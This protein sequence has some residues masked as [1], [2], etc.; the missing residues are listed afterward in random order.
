MRVRK[1]LPR[2]TSCTVKLTVNDWWQTD[3]DNYHWMSGNNRNDVDNRGNAD[4]GFAPP[5]QKAAGNPPSSGSFGYS[6]EVCQG[7][8]CTGLGGGAAI[9]EIEELVREHHFHQ[10]AADDAGGS[11]MIRVVTGGCRD[12]CTVGPNAHILARVPKE[13]RK[14]RKRTSLMES[15]QNVNDAPSCDRVVNSTIAYASSMTPD[16]ES[17]GSEA[18]TAGIASSSSS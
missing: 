6:I 17:G 9:L 11:A 18:T 16:R 14:G 8:D 2:T 12:F 7:P 13:Q 5:Q 3:K 4:D 1:L 10:N 15:F